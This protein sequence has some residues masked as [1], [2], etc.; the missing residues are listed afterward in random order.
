M[1]A[2][3]VSRWA[4]RLGGPGIDVEDVVQDVFLIVQRRLPE[5]RGEAQI[6]TWLY[7]ITVRVVQA[8]RRSLRVRRMLWPFQRAQDMTVEHSAP[9]SDP[10]HSLSA[11]QESALLYRLLDQL[12]EKYRLALVLFEIEGKSCKEIAALTGA[13]LANVWMRVSRGRAKLAQAY[14]RATTDGDAS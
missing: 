12:D 13:S 2:G 14:K 11:Q 9:A 1:H 4:E 10:A 7:E 5:F 8:K 3:S 6:T